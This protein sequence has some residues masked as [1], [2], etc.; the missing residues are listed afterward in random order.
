MITPQIF[1]DNYLFA[2]LSV[3]AFAFVIAILSHESNLTGKPISDTIPAIAAIA[4]CIILRCSS[5]S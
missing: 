5:W 3:A 2:L 1:K 4:A